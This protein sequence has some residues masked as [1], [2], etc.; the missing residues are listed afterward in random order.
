MSSIVASPSITAR[1]D[2]LHT[3]MK[4]GFEDEDDLDFYLKVFLGYDIPKHTF[5]P[6][7][8]SA[9]K[10][11][12]DV[13]FERVL[14]AL[15]FG[16]R[17]SGKTLAFALINHLKALF[18]T[19]PV[20]LVVASSQIHQTNIGYAYFKGFLEGDPLLWEQIDGDPIQSYTKFKNGS[21][22][23]IAS[24]T[25][26]G[27][28]GP[29]P[30]M[31]T[32]DEVELMDM[33]ILEQGLSMSMAKNGIPAQDILG[34][35]RKKSVGTMTTLLD[36]QVERNMSVY[37]FCISGESVVRTPR[38]DARI[39][40]LIGKSIY[41]Y[42]VDKHGN[43][44]LRPAKNIRKTQK[45]AEVYEVV[46]EWWAGPK[47]GMKRGSVV[48]TADHKFMLQ[49]GKY[50]QLKDL[51]IGDSLMPF[52]K[53]KSPYKGKNR[54]W[55]VGFTGSDAVREHCFVWEQ[56]HGPIPDGHVIHHKDGNDYNNNPRNLEALTRAEHNKHHLDH[57]F[58][59]ASDSKKKERSRKISES[60][61]INNPMHN[62]ESRKK[63]AE[64]W[65]NKSTKEQDELRKF[66]KE[67]AEL[68]WEYLTEKEYKDIC[69]N[70]GI[71]QLVRHR[72]GDN[73]KVVAIHPHGYE[74]VYC[75]EVEETHNFAVND[76]FVHN[77]I[78]ETL[79]K[80]TRE[81][82][83]DKNWGD[84]I[85]WDKCKGKAHDC[86]GWYPI[87]TFIQKTA[88]LSSKMFA[89]EWENKSPSGGAKVYG[90][91]YDENIHVISMLGGGKFKSFQSI[92][93]EKEI[94]KHWRRIGGMDFGAHFAF[95]IIVIE[96]RYDIW[97]LMYEYYY[98]GDRLLGT[99]A[100]N[101]KKHPYWRPRL[102]I[103]S[104]PSG[105]QSILEMRNYGLNCLSA[106]NDL[107]EGVDEVK[108]RLE[109][110]P[111][112]GLPKLFIMDI[113]TETRREF[114]VWEHGMLPDGKPDLDTYED[115]NDHC[116][117]GPI[118]YPI[119]TYPRMPKSY[120]KAT[121]IAGL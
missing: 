6:G 99:H 69:T 57:W 93:Q 80:C 87:S 33:P 50:K 25:M 118:R 48:A 116:L 44:V 90:E 32:I 92:F 84:C 60:K 110:N 54:G 1:R 62:P 70:M 34:S 51:N 63:A 67:L 76:I 88:N 59:T 31:T 77:C 20:E 107:A 74:D 114:D 52:T 73:H 95:G 103:Y 58:K 49:N 78:W 115:G 98:H 75:M 79:E 15:A 72:N 40:D 91:F 82:K 53:T 10:F 38:G 26:H 29:H 41:I 42:S 14:F 23:K 113:C 108:K 18:R 55:F 71:G 102:P 3:Y 19:S 12:T 43:L 11:I 89:T 8:I 37:Q 21:L 39:R 68:Q 94:P 96:P 5:C 119:F 111:A 27:L 9:F 28:N 85:A 112:N 101:I 47:G 66:H 2:L 83:G 65:S 61:K 86:Q 17:G 81:C 100:Q 97:I 24:G 64:W 35:T 13:V 46:Y 105:K 22:L 4:Y 36:E 7:H 104:D 30:N 16:S 45:N 120:V 121:T 109:I 117:D 106:M 56:V